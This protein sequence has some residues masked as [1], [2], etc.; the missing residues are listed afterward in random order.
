MSG[1]FQPFPLNSSDRDTLMRAL[2]DGGAGYDRWIDMVGRMADGLNMAALVAPN[3]ERA[4]KSGMAV[5][6]YQLRATLVHV[7]ETAYASPS[8]AGP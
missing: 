6:L 3:D 4:F 2:R 8:S 7:K 1:P 5:A